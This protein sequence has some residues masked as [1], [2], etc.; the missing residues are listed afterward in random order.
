MQRFLMIAFRSR[1]V[2]LRI[3]CRPIMMSSTDASAT[4]NALNFS[5]QVEAEHAIYKQF[6]QCSEFAAVVDALDGAFPNLKYEAMEENADYEALKNGGMTATGSHL[7]HVCG[8]HS[9]RLVETCMQGCIDH[10]STM[11]KLT[12]FISLLRSLNELKTGQIS[13]HRRLM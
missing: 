5:P 12:Q 3:P 6:A 10:D 2:E 4:N 11:S 8:N 13:H 9:N 7:A 1:I